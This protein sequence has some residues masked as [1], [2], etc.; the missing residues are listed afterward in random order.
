MGRFRKTFNEALDVA[1]EMMNN[2]KDL[3]V[4]EAAHKAAMI[5]SENETQLID[6]LNGKHIDQK[7]AD[8]SKD[9]ANVASNKDNTTKKTSQ[10][11]T[12]KANNT[13]KNSA[14]NKEQNVSNTQNSATK[15][16]T[17]KVANQATDDKAKKTKIKFQYNGPVEIIC[18]NGQISTINICE[19]VTAETKEQAKERLYEKL[20]NNRL[21][22]FISN[23]NWE[24]FLN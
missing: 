12:K 2:Q 4:E 21:P 23:K 8:D 9:S 6:A 3:T 17:K 10:K 15:T 14:K 22:I 18:L 19:A 16:R 1:R 20:F 13:K 24:S 11:K 7:K 5:C